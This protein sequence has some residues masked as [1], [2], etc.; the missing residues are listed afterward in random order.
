MHDLCP[1]LLATK[2]DFFF[3]LIA[4]LSSRA[5][6]G[7]NTVVGARQPMAVSRAGYVFATVNI[8]LMMSRGTAWLYFSLSRKLI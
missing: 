6:Q 7:K 1:F 2:V 3:F 8:D 4:L 5:I